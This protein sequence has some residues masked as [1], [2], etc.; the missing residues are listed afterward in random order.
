MV[1]LPPCKHHTMR[2]TTIHCETVA[3]FALQACRLCKELPEQVGG[4]VQ[5][6]HFLVVHAFDALTLNFLTHPPPI[7]HAP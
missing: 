6:P 3:C 1:P 4:H 2:H 7:S 5:I